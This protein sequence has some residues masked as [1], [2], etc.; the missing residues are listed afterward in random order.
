MK[1]LI[2]VFAFAAGLVVV[3]CSRPA[4]DA[5]HVPRHTGTGALPRAAS[6]SAV[7]TRPEPTQTPGTEPSRTQTIEF[8]RLFVEVSGESGVPLSHALVR[9]QNGNVAS[10]DVSGQ[11]LFTLGTRWRG[12]VIVGADGYAPWRSEDLTCEIGENVNLQARLVKGVELRVRVLSVGDAPVPGAAVEIR[13]NFTGGGVE[14]EDLQAAAQTDS[15][16]LAKFANLYS[17]PVTLAVQRKGYV[18]KR[19]RIALSTGGDPIEHTIVLDAARVVEV[20]VVNV[21]SG[22][23]ATGLSI[24]V[25]RSRGFIRH[26]GFFMTDERGEFRVDVP[27]DEELTFFDDTNAPCTFVSKSKH[28]RAM[29]SLIRARNRSSKDIRAVNSLASLA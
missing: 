20:H 21:D 25:M 28:S 12:N 16:G 27:S 15:N 14:D 22:G 17:M 23:P 7:A 24:G 2:I 26:L 19:E 3:Y 1:R 18:S 6:E 10:T 8:G 4:A 13:T 9:L 29:H 5:P 11:C